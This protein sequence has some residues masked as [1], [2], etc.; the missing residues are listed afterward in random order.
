MTTEATGLTPMAAN[1]E[2]TCCAF[3]TFRRRCLLRSRPRQ[4]AR[5]RVADTGVIGRGS[6]W[7][8]ESTLAPLK[9]V[10]AAATDARAARAPTS[11][12]IAALIDPVGWLT[13]YCAA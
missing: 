2:R 8:R 6:L 12:T 1:R 7:D 13:P 4:V 9:R 5:L 11:D 3:A 10:P